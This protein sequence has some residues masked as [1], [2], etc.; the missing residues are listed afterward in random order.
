[1]TNQ[2]KKTAVAASRTADAIV[3][4]TARVDRRVETS[5]L[6]DG[7]AFLRGF[8]AR[9]REIASVVPSS[10]FLE[11][12]VV[13]AAGL[14]DARCVVELGPGTGGTT[15]ALLRAMAPRARLLAI[16][17]NPSFCARLRH[18]LADARLIV[19]EGSA[20][21]LGEHLAHRGLPA[22][23]A[24]VSGIPF[25]T[26]PADAAQRVAAA[27]HAS[28]APGGRFVAYQL[29]AHVADYVTPWLGEATVEW[30]WRNVPPMRVFR[31]VKPRA[32]DA[33]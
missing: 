23:D 22:P 28:L 25:S 31:W 6:A 1:M 11:Q 32:N 33:S 12:R 20:E 9:P 24:V 3:E 30:E 27:I 2:T 5:R 16:E 15:R 10:V 8:L 29:R 4:F 21:A 13:R 18:R 19:Q 7:F 14:A 17:L 26:L